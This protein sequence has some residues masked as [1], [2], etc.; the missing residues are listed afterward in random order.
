MPRRMAPRMD[1]LAPLLSLSALSPRP[2]SLLRG[3]PLL[4]SLAVTAPM[5]SAPASLPV[6][7]SADLGARPIAFRIF[8][9][10]CVSF[11]FFPALLPRLFLFFLLLPPLRAGHPT[12]RPSASP[13]SSF[14]SARP[15]P[16][17]ASSTFCR[18]VLRLFSPCFRLLLH[19]PPHPSPP[20]IHSQTSLLPPPLDSAH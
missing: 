13:Q 19:P 1:R 16:R 8:P 9:S 3:P 14:R 10:S 18:R 7:F 20:T 15:R 5:A 2:G 4:L 6:H 17:P 11:F 12:S